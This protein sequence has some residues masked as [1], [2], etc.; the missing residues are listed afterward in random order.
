MFRDER[1]FFGL[2]LFLGALFFEIG[3]SIGTKLGELKA[4]QYEI[5]FKE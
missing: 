2:C 4:N 3:I 5:L 1:M